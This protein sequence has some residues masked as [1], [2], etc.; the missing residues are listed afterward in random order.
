MADPFGLGRIQELGLADGIAP[1]QAD[2]QV[3]GVGVETEQ[4][5]GGHGQAQVDMALD[6]AV[7]TGVVEASV[8]LVGDARRRQHLGPG[9][10]YPLTDGEHGVHQ[11]RPD[12]NARAGLLEVE[13]SGQ[14]GVDARSQLAGRLEAAP[15]NH[16]FGG[17]AHIAGVVE[18]LPTGDRQAPIG[19]AHCVDEQ[20]L[21]PLPCSVRDVFESR[22]EQF[23]DQLAGHTHST[24]L[25]L[26]VRP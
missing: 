25:L 5:G 24:D 12:M 26:P 14:L 2:R 11:G 1:R 3:G 7:V 23:L 4:P 15:Q 20:A 10:A 8:D 6:V 13:R 17:T 22:I 21:H 9:G 19:G 16:R 18:Q